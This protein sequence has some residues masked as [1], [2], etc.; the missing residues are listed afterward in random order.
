MTWADKIKEIL[1]GGDTGGP[2]YWRDT[3]KQLLRSVEIMSEM[4]YDGYL[5]LKLVLERHT[6][7]LNDLNRRLS[8][9]EG[10]Q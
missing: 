4:S 8:V 10:E 9:L 5:N 6:Q 2:E 1:G 7:A 3:E